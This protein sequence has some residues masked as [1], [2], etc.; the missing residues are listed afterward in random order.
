M[1]AQE[2]GGALRRGGTNRG[3]T[4]RPPHV[5]RDHFRELLAAQGT[6][7]LAEVLAGVVHFRGKC[8]KCSHVQTRKINHASE[9]GE[10]TRVVEVLA[11]FGIGTKDELNLISP[12]V[13][14]RVQETVALI[15]SRADWKS[16]ELLEALDVIW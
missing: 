1:E 9:S 6:K 10:R 13:R 12:E 8:E 14:T 11:R 3:G 5:I 7:H 16:T 4:G 15:A 2:H